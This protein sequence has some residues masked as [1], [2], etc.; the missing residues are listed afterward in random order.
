MRQSF[1]EGIVLSK[2]ANGVDGFEVHLATRQKIVVRSD[3]HGHTSVLRAPAWNAHLGC[4][5][6]EVVQR[7]ED[8]R[9]K[10]GGF[11]LLMQAGE[12]EFTT[13][14]N[15]GDRPPM[16]GPI[17]PRSDPTQGDA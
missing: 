1:H 5:D 3:H 7:F 2:K 13:L 17:V 10:C 11:L 12:W 8:G 16:V 9:R 6:P 15:D 14:V 4:V